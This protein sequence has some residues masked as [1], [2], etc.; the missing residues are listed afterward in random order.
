[1]SEISRRA[2]FAGACGIA[3]ATIPSLSAEAA[4]AVTKLANGKLSVRVRDI[5]ELAKVGGSARIGTFKGKPVALARTGA[6]A[7]V[8]FTLN[9][10]HQGVVVEKV[11]SQ[12]VC[13]AH[14]SK[15]ESNGDL[16]F[17]PA[18]TGLPRVKSKVSKGQVII[19]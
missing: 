5:P 13:D 16:N 10:P 18:T 14:G 6:N 3:M 7:F 17:G 9:C 8:A 12:W 19:G 1:M 15:F 2:L 11:E 4:G